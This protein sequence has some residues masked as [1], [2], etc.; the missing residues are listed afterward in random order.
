VDFVVPDELVEKTVAL[1]KNRGLYECF[2]LATCKIP[3]ESGLSPCPAGHFHFEPGPSSSL[4][5]HK[6]SKTLWFLPSLELSSKLGIDPPDIILASD[7]ILP[8][9]RISGGHGSFKSS[10]FLVC[11]PTP[12]RF[13]EASIRLISSAQTSNH[14]S[15]WLTT[16]A[17]IREYV[18]DEG[19]LD[20][21]SLDSR[22]KDFYRRWLKK[23][24]PDHIR[25][26]LPMLRASFA[27]SGDPISPDAVLMDERPSGAPAGR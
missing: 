18:D 14:L 11:I 22:C 19:I 4:S 24:K 15:F 16:V 6:K 23:R 10:G 7:P 27:D 1:L 2:D 20:E 21:E 13:L 26:L 17:Y 8:P 5:I 9:A 25:V 3:Q 12:N